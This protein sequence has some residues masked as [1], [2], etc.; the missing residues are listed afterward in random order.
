MLKVLNGFL[1][2][3]FC[4]AGNILAQTTRIDRARAVAYGRD[5]ISSY[6][7]LFELFDHRYSMPVDSL[8]VYLGRAKQIAGDTAAEESKL[9]FQLVQLMVDNRSSQA[10]SLIHRTDSILKAIRKKN[11]I[12]DFEMRFLHFKAAALM[13]SGKYKE[14]LSVYYSVLKM[15][16]ERR[17]VEFI[18]ASWNGVGWVH[19][20]IGKHTEAISFLRKAIGIVPDTAFNGRPNV[21]YNNLAACF[22]T[23]G[24]YDSAMKYV[25]RAEKNAREAENLQLLANALA[26]KSDILKAKGANQAVIQCL[27]EMLDTRRKIGDVFYVVSD[28]YLLAQFYAESGDCSKGIL[29]CKDALE[30]IKRYKIRAKEMIIREALALN[31]KACREYKLFGEEMEILGSLKDSVN[32]NASAEALAEMQAKYELE[33]KEEKIIRQELELSK[34]NYLMYGSFALLLMGVLVTF[35]Y[36]RYY[37]HR[38]RT[39]SVMAV[40][41]AKDEERKRIAAE[42]HDNI[43]TQLGFISRKI[44]MFKRSS[45]P[46]NTAESALL[47]EISVASRKT[48]GDLRETIWAL[49]KEQVDFRDL[50]DRLKLFFRRQF[51]EALNVKQEIVEDIRYDILLS[52]VE[53]LNIFRIVQ[54]ALYNAALHAEADTVRLTAQADAGGS[55]SIT[56]EDNGKGFDVLKVYED[57]YGLV[58]MKERARESD[59]ELTIKSVQGKG[60]VIG[61]KNKIAAS[62]QYTS[63]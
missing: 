54:E 4:C 35:Q 11:M 31:Y 34:R 7:A 49:K 33:Q 27:N 26:I 16:E 50:A 21:I 51:G 30:L 6:L 2:L 57:H 32:R 20:E 60:T 55:W 36:F 19:M 58:N 5:A 28:M 15:A 43:G 14:A 46:V 52:A 38:S 61:I 29:I 22:S 44:D 25:Q 37:K 13:R 9:Y 8:E 40:N 1:L 53:S 62:E 12:T 10:E 3:V 59:L 17:N 56:I 41:A 39:E 24:Q 47:E 42:L 48:I 23:L 18:C 45:E 63:L